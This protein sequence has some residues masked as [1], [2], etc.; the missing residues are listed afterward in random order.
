MRPV[1]DPTTFDTPSV[2]ASMFNGFNQFNDA[3][4][5]DL[6]SPEAL[7]AAFGDIEEVVRLNDE[8][9]PFISPVGG[10]SE[11][12]VLLLKCLNYI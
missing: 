10:V 3:V 12:G 7:R 9:Q 1:F 6:N 2:S 5:S 4:E 8:I 11:G